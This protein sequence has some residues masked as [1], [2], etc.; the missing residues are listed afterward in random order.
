MFQKNEL[1]E[2]SL[3]MREE[4]AKSD[5]GMAAGIV[6]SKVIM[7]PELDQVRPVAG[8]IP[9][10]NELDCLI[11]LKALHAAFFPI[12]LPSIVAKGQALD[13]RVWGMETE[14]IDGPFGT[15][16]PTEARVTPEIVL[17]PLVAFDLKGGRIGYGG[18][19]YDRTIKGLKENN[20]CLVTIGVAY[21][22]QQL[23][24]I[25]M[26]AHDQHLDM[27]ITEKQIHRFSD[28]ES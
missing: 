8:Y 22:A 18:G 28:L 21:E 5:D 2:K 26:E 15:K 6:A 13:F 20:M 12:A 11:I 16:Q 23:D 1:R 24:D 3:K 7:L 9:I 4:A 19:F 17:V 27:V 14:L 10:K 25:P